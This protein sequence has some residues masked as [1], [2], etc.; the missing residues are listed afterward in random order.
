MMCSLDSLPTASQ[1]G[2]ESSGVADDEGSGSRGRGWDWIG[3]WNQSKQLEWAKP[4][5]SSRRM[6]T[7]QTARD[8]ETRMESRSDFEAA[9]I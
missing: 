2:V 7:K 6:K 3:R 5:S 4:T 8:L 9:L 1:V